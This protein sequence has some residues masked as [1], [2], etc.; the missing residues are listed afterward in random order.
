MSGQSL[1]F[2]ARDAEET[3]DFGTRLADLFAAGDLVVLI[4]DL[5]AGKT[6]LVQGL[7]EHLGVRG[8]ITSPTYIV[9][10]VHRSLGGGPDLIHVDAYR[11][12]DDL[13]M[14]TIDLET[15]LDSAVTVVE[16]GS[17]KVD[18]LSED[19]FVIEI[20][21]DDEDGRLITVS[22]TGSGT[23]DRLDTW[24]TATAN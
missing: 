6:T 13:D 14:E 15:S 1:T 23:R 10:R 2:H 12:G 16:W 17:G 24:L 20:N 7:G 9:S 18:H 22:A 4:G 21:F 8:R 11:V 3:R 19:R 5:G